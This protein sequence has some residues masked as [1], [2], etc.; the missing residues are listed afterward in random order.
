MQKPVLP[1]RWRMS[2]F[3][4][5]HYLPKALKLVNNDHIKIFMLV[6]LK[7]VFMFVIF[8]YLCGHV[9]CVMGHC[10]MASYCQSLLGVQKAVIIDRA[11][12]LWSKATGPTFR[13]QD[14]EM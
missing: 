3:L 2:L 6:W 5:S 13:A 14:E 10:S 11:K 1:Q 12:A 7:N 4:L 8:Q 9:T